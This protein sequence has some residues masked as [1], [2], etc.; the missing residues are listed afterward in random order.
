MKIRS[1][2]VTN[3]SSVTY[4]VTMPD[5]FTISLIEMNKLFD[6][7]D[8]DIFGPDTPE[9]RQQILEDVLSQ[10]DNLKKGQMVH[11]EDCNFNESFNVLRECLHEHDLVIQGIDSNSD[12]D[13][14]IIPITMETI[15]K[16]ITTM[17]TYNGEDIMTN[18]INKQ[19]MSKK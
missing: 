7:G 4:I 2:F 13:N 3:S 16:I 5:T 12:G 8:F 14:M 17:S 9:N 15:T 11:Q 18:I 1:G 19:G 10:V 6:N